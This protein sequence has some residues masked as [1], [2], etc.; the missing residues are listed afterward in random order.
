M[1]FFRSLRFQHRYIFYSENIFKKGAFLGTVL[2]FILRIL[3]LRLSLFLLRKGL[4]GFLL[5][6]T[7]ASIIYGL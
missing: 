1:V 6:K 7:N 2:L 4:A 5:V 3:F